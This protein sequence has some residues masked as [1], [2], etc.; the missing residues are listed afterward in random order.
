MAALAPHDDDLLV[1]VRL[2]MSS[3]YIA[4]SFG[5]GLSS[6]RPLVKSSLFGIDVAVTC[7][8][9]G[10]L[11]NGEAVCCANFLKCQY[12]AMRTYSQVPIDRGFGIERWCP[13][14][15]SRSF[16]GRIRACASQAASRAHRRERRQGFKIKWMQYVNGN[17]ERFLG[18]T[19]S[20]CFPRWRNSGQE[21]SEAQLMLSTQRINA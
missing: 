15:S 11:L 16:A 5:K 7:T 4:T 14:A 21:G 9:H 1:M 2:R 8:K 20:A 17:N 13:T 12:G 10:V 18:G 19:E 3:T 6:F